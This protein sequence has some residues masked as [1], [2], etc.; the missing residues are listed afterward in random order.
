MITLAIA[1]VRKDYF[2]FLSKPRS[3]SLCSP[4]EGEGN[5]FSLVRTC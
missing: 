5:D 4:L 1:L 2:P 3:V